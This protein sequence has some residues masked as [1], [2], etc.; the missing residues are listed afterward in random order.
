MLKMN[1]LLMWMVPEKLVF[2]LERLKGLFIGHNLL[3]SLYPCFFPSQ[4]LIDDEVEMVRGFD[5][6]IIAPFRERLKIPGRL[7]N[8]KDLHLS[9]AERKLMN[10]YNEKPVLSCPQHEFYLVNFSP[11]FQTSLI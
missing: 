8:M 11:T 7:V 3:I 5:L 9:A 6:D 2:I 1:N 10:A 4:R